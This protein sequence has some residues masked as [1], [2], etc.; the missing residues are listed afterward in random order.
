MTHAIYIL[1]TRDFKAQSPKRRHEKIALLLTFVGAMI[2]CARLFNV[3]IMKISLNK[4]FRSGAVLFGIRAHCYPMATEITTPVALFWRRAAGRISAAA[5][6][7]ASA[8]DVRGDHA[9]ASDL[10]DALVIMI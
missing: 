5:F 10:A 1:Q 6:L 7:S 8:T 2:N 4:F 3:E 9:M